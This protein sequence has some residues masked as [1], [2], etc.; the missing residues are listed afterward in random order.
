MRSGEIDPRA[1]EDISVGCFVDWEILSECGYLVGDLSRAFFKVSVLLSM[2]KHNY[3]VPL[4]SLEP[5][6]MDA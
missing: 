5:A 6:G 1:M 2:A 3:L 4:Q